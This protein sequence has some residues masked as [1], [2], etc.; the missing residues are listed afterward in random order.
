MPPLL[1]QAAQGVGA[2]QAQPVFHHMLPVIHP[3]IPTASIPGWRRMDAPGTGLSGGQKQQRLCIGRTI[4]TSPDV[5]LMDEPGS[6]LDP[7]AATITEN[8][9]IELAGH[10]TVVIVTHATQQ[11]AVFHLGRLIAP[12]SAAKVSTSPAQPQPRDYI[13]G[14]CG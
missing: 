3:G 6:W 9:I 5:V 1:R 12:G 2:S 13:S 7:I 14:R 8:L 4:A 11:A 10:Y